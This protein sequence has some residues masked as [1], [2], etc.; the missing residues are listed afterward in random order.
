MRKYAILRN[1]SAAPTAEPFSRRATGLTAEGGATAHP[2][3]HIEVADLSSKDVR[4]LARDPQVQ[5]IA[6]VMPTALIRPFEVASG[7]AA[8][9]AWGI[10]AVKADVSTFTGAGVTVAVLDTG[11]DKSHAAF[12]GV[13]LIEQD[14]SGAGNGDVVGHGTHCAGTIFGRDVNGTRI[15]VAR[16]VNKALIGKVL[17]NDGSGDSDMIFRG[18]QWAVQEG[19]QVISMSLGFNFPGLVDRLIAQSWPAELATSVA[20]EAYRGNLRMFDALMEMVLARS[21]FGVG[22]VV[23]A[24]AGNESRRDENP[25]FE[26]AVS[27]PAAAQGIV[28]VG[29]LAQ[30]GT[31]LVVAPFSN[32]F[33][34]V[35]AP[36]VNILSAKVGGGLKALNG[37]SMATPHVAGVAALWWEVHKDTPPAIAAA[38][39][40]A[41]LLATARTG[42]FSSEVDPADRG[43][44]IVTAP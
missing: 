39:V 4:D 40:N 43:L 15:G 24:A 38:A 34:Q 30:Q 29:A 26:I 20:L 17:S 3:P 37:T 27:I 28:S 21:A 23:V 36:G 32:T 7:E 35:S 5:N 19:A 11:I 31:G 9:G 16:G 1:M 25:E 13:Q 2:I 14:F 10:G 6:P 33:P 41:R 12:Q 42:G 18:I 44:G 22:T 8:T